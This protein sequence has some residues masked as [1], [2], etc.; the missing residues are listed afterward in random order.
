MKIACIADM[1]G[2]L[3]ETIP[4]C[5]VI[6]IA[7]DICPATGNH[8]Y[9][10]QMAWL[11]SDFWHWV[12]SVIP[13]H[14]EVV[15]VAGNHDWCFEVSWEPA[16]FLDKMGLTYLQ[17]SGFNYGGL[18]FYGHP[19][20]PAF[21]GWAFNS[22]TEALKRHNDRIPEGTDVLVTHGPPTRILDKPGGSHEHCGC[23]YLAGRIFE[24]KPKLHVFGHIHG[25]YGTQV[26]GTT[27]YVNA[28]YV[29]ERY[30]PG[31]PETIRVVEL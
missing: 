14:V 3:P 26:M 5:D 17:D 2:H 28:S 19:W 18:S 29:D 1:H 8:E 23:K 22:G 31:G 16:Q 10:A 15:V 12:N 20:T 27:R 25:S 21:C 11:K 13:G 24:V 30:S 6:V 7:G 9:E 4:E